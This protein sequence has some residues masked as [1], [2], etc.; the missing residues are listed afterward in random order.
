VTTN[1][2][3]LA[4][5]HT[6]NMV[7]GFSRADLTMTKTEIFTVTLLHPCKKTLLTTTQTI[8]AM[9]YIFGDPA[10]VTGFTAFN[11]SVAL[12]YGVPTLCALSYSLSPSAD[13]TKYAVTVDTPTLKIQVVTA[14]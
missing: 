6:V 11:D 12:Q 8:A 9:N 3:N 10:M 5:P 13:A 7:V 1:D 4:G 2:Y 14:D